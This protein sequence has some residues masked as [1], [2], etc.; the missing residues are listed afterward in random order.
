[1]AVTEVRARRAPIN[2]WRK[3]TPRRPRGSARS[4]AVPQPI[5][6][7][8]E[9][10]KAEQQI[11]ARRA[12]PRAAVVTRET[13][14]MIRIYA[15]TIAPARAPLRLRRSGENWRLCYAGIEGGGYR[16]GQCGRGSRRNGRRALLN[17]SS[18]RDWAANRHVSRQRFGRSDRNRHRF[19]ERLS[20]RRANFRRGLPGQH[21]L[22]RRGDLLR[23]A[24]P[25]CR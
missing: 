15:P 22:L 3:S 11:V 10:A 20:D 7:L 2:Q 6:E 12:G 19:Q 1:M 8:V 23:D 25:G 21:F 24:A 18:C 9:A 13:T 16:P 5:Q 17:V 4:Q 14:T